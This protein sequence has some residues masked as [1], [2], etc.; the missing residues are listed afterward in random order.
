M[1][2]NYKVVDIFFYVDDM[3]D[4]CTSN[5]QNYIVHMTKIQKALVVN[6]MKI[7]CVV[8]PYSGFVTRSI[9]KQ[10]EEKSG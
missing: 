10:V 7:A 5:L 8:F 1:V 2:A 9:V 6:K 4:M 3:I